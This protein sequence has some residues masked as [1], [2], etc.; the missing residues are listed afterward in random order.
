[1]FV[2]AALTALVVIGTAEALISNDQ[3]SQ[4]PGRARPAL[5]AGGAAVSVIGIGFSL[6]VYVSLG[7]V[8]ARF[9]ARDAAVLATGM[10]VGAVAGLIGGAIRAYLIRDYLGEV[11]EGYGLGSLVILTLLMFVALS[12]AV[13]LTAGAG[14]TWL[15]FRAARRRPTQPPP[16]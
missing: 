14:A 10:A 5:S 7:V 6:A 9:R 3:L 2:L 15:G 13:S 11:L 4:L 12:I 16:S 8:M 1:V